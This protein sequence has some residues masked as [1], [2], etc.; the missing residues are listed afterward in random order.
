MP[1]SFPFANVGP[2]E[3]PEAEITSL[4]PNPVF[5]IPK[6]KPNASCFAVPSSESN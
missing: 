6:K 3:S 1:T 4:F 2:P 5:E